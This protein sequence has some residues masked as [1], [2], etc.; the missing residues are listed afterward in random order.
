MIK[1]RDG[2]SHGGSV[3]ADPSGLILSSLLS[4][5]EVDLKSHLRRGALSEELKGLIQ[6]AV[7]QKPERHHLSEG[8][9]PKGRAMCQVG[10]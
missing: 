10:G 7:A 1:F 6:Q 8:I 3:S 4:D 2:S 5:E 9:F